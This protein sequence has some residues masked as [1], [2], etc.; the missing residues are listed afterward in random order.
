MGSIGE[1]YLMLT[2]HRK[3][4]IS[5]GKTI[6]MKTSE[7]LIAT[8]CDPENKVCISGSDEDRQILQEAIEEVQDLE[9]YARHMHSHV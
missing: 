4:E 1:Y 5:G 2:I 3:R 7:K 9:K 8:L 6:Y